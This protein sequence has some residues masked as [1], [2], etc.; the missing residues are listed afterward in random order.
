MLTRMPAL[1]FKLNQDRHHHIPGQ[2]RKVTNWREYDGSFAKK[3]ALAARNIL[4]RVKMQGCCGHPG[5]P[6]C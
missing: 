5:E 4:L 3:Y 6:G 2:K 1:P